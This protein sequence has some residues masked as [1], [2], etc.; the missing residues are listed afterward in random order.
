MCLLLARVD[1]ARVASKSNF[2]LY[3]TRAADK[4]TYL[5]SRIP[6]PKIHCLNKI[7]LQKRCERIVCALGGQLDKNLD[8]GLGHP[9]S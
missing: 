4:L 8:T 5:L 1:V 6:H 7:C 9:L 2:C 3:S